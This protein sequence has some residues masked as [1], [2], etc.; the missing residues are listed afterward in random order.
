VLKSSSAFASG[1]EETKAVE[2]KGLIELK[3]A[4]LRVPKVQV[5]SPTLFDEILELDYR[6]HRFELAKVEKL[7]P[8][9]KSFVRTVS[10]P[11]VSREQP[12]ARQH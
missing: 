6:M 11:L 3:R 5:Y 7:S 2:A 12:R 9:N 10:A 1:G 4:F 8:S